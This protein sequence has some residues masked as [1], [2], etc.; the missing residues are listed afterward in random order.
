MYEKRPSRRVGAL[1]EL[2]GLLILLMVYYHGAYDAA[3]IFGADFPFFFSRPMQ[4]LQTFISCGFIIISGM[5]ARFSRNNLRRG[6]Q[7][8]GLGLLLTAATLFVMPDQ[9]VMF[10]I[11]HFLGSAMILFALFE[12]QLDKI[13]T[14][15]GAPLFVAIFILT[16]YIPRGMLGYPPFW[17]PLPDMLYQTGFLFPLGFPSDGFFSSDYFP[18]IPNLFLFFGA[19]YL[20]VYAKNG[21]IPEFCY[22]TRFS[23][24]AWVGR[25]TIW[26]YML[27][28]PIVYAFL[29]IYFRLFPAA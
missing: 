20:G 3:V 14:V 9:R 7:V 17:T 8:L 18:L 28:Q 25:H 11:L 22:R 19:T 23:W 5:S 1:D 29:W 4:W 12:K 10:G 2:R 15:L 16:L 26:V 13:P 21:Q 27:H 6:V 24:L